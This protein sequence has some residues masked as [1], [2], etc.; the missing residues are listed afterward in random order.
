[1]F[2]K[3]IIGTSKITVTFSEIKIKP[4]I[5]TICLLSK[6]TQIQKQSI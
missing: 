4:L 5:T 3:I 2:L 6:S 1:M